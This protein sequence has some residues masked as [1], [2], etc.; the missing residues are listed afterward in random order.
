MANRS[1]NIYGLTILSPIRRDEAARVS[2]SLELRKY[3]RQL[4]RHESSPFAR[5]A[6]T[7]MA[8]LVIMD[9]VVFVGSP[10]REEHLRYK[11]LVFEANFD[12]ELEPFLRRMIREAP[13]E[14]REIWKHCE[15]FPGTDDPAKFFDYMKKCQVG[16]TF[17]FVDVNDKTL[18]DTLKALQVQSAIASFVEK[19]QGRS[20]A[21]LKQAFLEFA[22]K[23]EVAKIPPPASVRGREFTGQLL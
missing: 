18:P 6:G 10:S 5:I 22:T 9:D 14:V 13:E 7:H 17:Y 16:T 11:Y 3:L 12:G 21:P 8:R 1:G 23:L 2:P 19:S 4:D 15:A 20:G